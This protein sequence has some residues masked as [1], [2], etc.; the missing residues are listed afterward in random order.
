MSAYSK[1]SKLGS[2]SCVKLVSTLCLLVENI[3]STCAS[4]REL[5]GHTPKTRDKVTS[6]LPKNT[7]KSDDVST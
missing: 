1:R 2:L 6:W 4:F 5:A 3:W 7:H